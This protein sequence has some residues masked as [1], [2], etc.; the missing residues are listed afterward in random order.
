MLEEPSN[1]R[2]FRG[3]LS[4]SPAEALA[5]TRAEKRLDGVKLEWTMGSVQPSD[6]VKATTAAPIFISNRVQELLSAGE[7]SGWQTY[8]VEVFGRDGIQFHGYQ[9]LA[10][11]GRC[12]AIDSARSVPFDKAMPAGT[13][14][15]FRGLYFD[16]STWDGSDI[17]MPAEAVGWIFVVE[18]VRNA[19]IA[20]RVKNVVLT[21][22]DQVERMTR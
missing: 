1:S 3:R 4:F 5:Q 11:H 8:P 9:G 16:P 6:I 13:F 2:A 20:S 12:G 15:W 17:F 14:T 21:P 10:V 22:L 19:L 18:S 7:F